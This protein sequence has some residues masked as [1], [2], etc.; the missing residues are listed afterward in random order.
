M[1]HFLGCHAL[2]RKDEHPLHTGTVEIF[3][4]L[5]TADPGTD[6]DPNLLYDRRLHVP[7]GQESGSYIDGM[8]D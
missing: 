3:S 4:V 2:L 6:R 8:R 1:L 5:A 7:V